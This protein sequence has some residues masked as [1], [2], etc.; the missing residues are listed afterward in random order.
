MAY[1]RGSPSSDT[2]PTRGERWNVPGR[3]A[4]LPRPLTDRGR[5]NSERARRVC[6]SPLAYLPSIPPLISPA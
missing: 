6:R 1:G 2:T 5:P 3:I 4:V